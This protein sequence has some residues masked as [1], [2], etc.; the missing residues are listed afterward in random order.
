[1]HRLAQIRKTLVALGA[2]LVDLAVALGFSE[3]DAQRWIGLGVTII[4]AAL[5]Y[6]IPNA[7]PSDKP[8]AP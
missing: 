6:W 3:S 5:V 7:P 4:S 2:A 1:M 8:A